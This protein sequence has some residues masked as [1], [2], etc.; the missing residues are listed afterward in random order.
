[1][2]LPPAQAQR[3]FDYYVG[4]MRVNHERLFQYLRAVL[5][6]ADLAAVPAPV[7]LPN[8][9]IYHPAYDKGVFAD[10]RSYLARGRHARA[11]RRGA[12]RWWA[13]RCR[14]VTCPTADPCA[15][16]NHCRVGSAWRA[17]AGVLPQRR[18]ARAAADG[19]S[20]NGSD[21]AGVADLRPGLGGVRCRWPTLL[22]GCTRDRASPTPQ[23]L[24]PVEVTSPSSRWT[25]R[26]CRR[27]CWSTPFWASTRRAQG[28]AP[29]HG[30]AGHQHAVVPPGHAG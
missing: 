2:G 18:V 10:L 29:R 12:R 6:G 13:W 3:V 4:G 24:A 26:R 20:C 15:R 14:P 9:G 30:R 23:E 22:P 8:G 25:A 5:Q 19:A 11:A 21:P 17:A 27:C 16:R 1:M 28:L 7:A